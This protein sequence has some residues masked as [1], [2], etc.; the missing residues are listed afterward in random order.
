MINYIEKNAYIDIYSTTYVPL[1]DLCMLR[2]TYV[3]FTNLKHTHWVS[4]HVPHTVYSAL[5]T[6]G[7]KEKSFTFPGKRMTGSMSHQHVRKV[8]TTPITQ[9]HA[10]TVLGNNESKSLRP[11]LPTMCALA[12]KIQ[13]KRTKQKFYCLTDRYTE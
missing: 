6:L 8:I 12:K 1:F 4:P 7:K 5:I 11:D 13:A 3:G 9:T 10:T 2:H